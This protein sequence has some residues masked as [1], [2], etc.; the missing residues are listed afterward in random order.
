MFC[1]VLSVFIFLSIICLTISQNPAKPTIALTVANSPFD[2]PVKT[3]P[4]LWLNA[5]KSN[6][7]IEKFSRNNRITKRDTD[8]IEYEYGC[9]EGY[10]WSECFGPIA[11]WNCGFGEWCYT[12]KTYSQS[13][14]YVKC[15]NKNDCNR[16]W[17]CAGPCA[18]F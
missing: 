18:A 14:L 3:G 5:F 4:M 6:D 15:N 7:M 9:H 11:F 16:E 1:K 12:T 10:C 13:Y 17:K 8:D 2:L